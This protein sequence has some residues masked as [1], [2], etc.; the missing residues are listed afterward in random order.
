MGSW[1]WHPGSPALKRIRDALVA[2]GDEWREA[3]ADVGPDWNLADGEKL[4]R[5]P[6][7]YSKDH[8]LIEDIKRKSFAVTSKLTQK[9]ATAGGFL[10]V[11]EARAAK[12]RP[13]MA[14]LSSALGVEY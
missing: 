9:E 1:I 2:R 8:P 10:D 11:V 3:V 5:P 4:K 6:A 14:F 7:G 13:F 12:A